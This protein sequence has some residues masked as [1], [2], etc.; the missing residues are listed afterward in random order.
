MTDAPRA[1]G[2]VAGALEALRYNPMVLGVLLLNV[3]FVLG[4]LWYLS[5]A[6]TLRNDNLKM[7]LER[8]LPK[9]SG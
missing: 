3:L 4:G 2:V 6:E 8:C 1:P 9:G 7:I 5:K